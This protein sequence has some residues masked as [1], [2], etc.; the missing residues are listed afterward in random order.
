MFERILKR[1]REK[2]RQRQ[3]VMTLHRMFHPLSVKITKNRYE[4]AFSTLIKFTV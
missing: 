3:Y 4:F 2:I 1:M